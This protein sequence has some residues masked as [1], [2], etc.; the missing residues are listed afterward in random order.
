VRQLIIRKTLDDEIA[1][2]LR[3]RI[4][5]LFDKL[6]HFRHIATRFD[7]RALY[8]LAALHIGSAIIA[9]RPMSIR[10]S[11]DAGSCPYPHLQ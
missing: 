11:C 5:R 1:A 7:R 4:E 6:K 8:F 9:E 2:K 3:D 10:P